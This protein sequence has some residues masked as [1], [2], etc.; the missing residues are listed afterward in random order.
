M[1]GKDLRHAR[2][3]R[4]WTQQRTAQTFGMSQ[5]Y[6]SLLKKGLRPLTSKLMST[7]LDTFDMPPLSLPLASEFPELK[8]KS[9][10]WA[11]HLGSLGY[12]GFSYFKNRPTQNPAEVLLGALKQSD[13]DSRVAKGL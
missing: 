2:L 3:A 6:L 1:T 5:A 11:C 13:L 12:P 7:A 9:E 4:G 8:T 10:D